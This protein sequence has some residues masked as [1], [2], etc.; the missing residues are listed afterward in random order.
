[1]RARSVGLLVVEVEPGLGVGAPGVLG[2][3]EHVAE[4]GQVG[5]VADLED[6]RGEPCHRA[7]GASF[8]EARNFERIAGA[9]V[10]PGIAD[11]LGDDGQ[12]AAMRSDGVGDF[13][14]VGGGD[15][16]VGK[17]CWRDRRG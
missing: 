8:A 10:D 17:A 11:L 6:P 5:G 2:L 12:V 13:R 14:K 16:G 4:E 9:A 7:G 15:L 3:E 1:M